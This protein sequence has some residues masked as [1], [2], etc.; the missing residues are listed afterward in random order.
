MAAPAP[1]L[2]PAGEV[3]G[4]GEQQQGEGGGAHH[5]HRPRHAAGEHRGRGQGG[6]G[7]GARAEQLDSGVSGAEVSDVLEDGGWGGHRGR[8]LTGLPGPGHCGDGK[9]QLTFCRHKCCTLGY[10]GEW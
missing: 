9:L 5:H 4:Q 7:G 8:A 10:M 3:G 2:Q 1:P 6:A